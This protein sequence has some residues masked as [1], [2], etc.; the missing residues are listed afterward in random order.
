MSRRGMMGRGKATSLEPPVEKTELLFYA[1]LITDKNPIFS[2]DGNLG[3]QQAGSCII[4]A[5]TL[6]FASN[7][8][9]A[10][11]WASSIKSG[12]NLTFSCIV[13][14]TYSSGVNVM[15]GMLHQSITTR[16]SGLFLSKHVSHN[17]LGL[18]SNY[19]SPFSGSPAPPFVTSGETAFVSWTIIFN[20]NS[21]YTVK[22][23]NNGTLVHQV[24]VNQVDWLGV[25]NNAPGIGLSGNNSCAGRYSHFSIHEELSDTQILALYQNGG[26]AM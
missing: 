20:G 21:S 26:I 8:S 4:D 19:I 3:I 11:R 22:Y 25:A 23:Y 1:P 10:I 15:F 13:K 5:G 14:P 24:T 7:G 17:Y 6:Y 2:W 12:V 18:I 16:C 9:T